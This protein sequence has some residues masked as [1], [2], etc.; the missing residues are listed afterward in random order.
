MCCP[1]PITPTPPIELVQVIRQQRKDGADFVKI[2]ETGADSMRATEFHTPYQYTR[3][4][5]ESGGGRGGAAG[6]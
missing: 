1:M 2:Y 5:A 6:H 4:A 3:G